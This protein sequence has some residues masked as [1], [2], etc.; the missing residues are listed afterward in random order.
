MSHR[1]TLRMAAPSIV[2]S[3][4]LFTLGSLGALYVRNLQKSTEATLRLDRET[5]QA[6]GQLLLSVTEVRAELA[7]FLA[8]GSRAHLEAVPAKLAEMDRCLRET[9]NLVDDENEMALTRN[10]RAD[11]RIS[12]SVPADR[13]FPKSLG[14]RGKA[15]RRASEQ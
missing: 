12:R 9:E 7:E 4:L 10:I 14:R 6:A 2:I 3:L 13:R 15:G 11:T 1:L 5:I 8:S